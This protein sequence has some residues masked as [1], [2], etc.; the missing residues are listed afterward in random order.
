MET[1]KTSEGEPWS[2]AA[3]NP[4]E[5][6]QAASYIAGMELYFVLMP[7]GSETVQEELET[8]RDEGMFLTS[9]YRAKWIPGITR[10]SWNWNYL[11]SP[12]AQMIENSRLKKLW[13]LP[14]LFSSTPHLHTTRN[15]PGSTIKTCLGSNYHS[16]PPLFSLSRPSSSPV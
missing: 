3:E 6:K 13:R 12:L 16:P 14:G 1:A 8:F 7:V 5:F 15:L 9:I 11:F 10:L 2:V 4:G